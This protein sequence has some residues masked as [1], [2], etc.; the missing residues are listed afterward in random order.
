VTFFPLALL[1]S[2]AVRARGVFEA[3]TATADKLNALVETREQEI[4]AGLRDLQR[5]EREALLLEERARIMRDMHD[6]IGGQ[7]LGLVMRARANRLSGPAL[8]HGLEESLDDL[9]LMVGS[10]EQSDGSLATA[11]G[12]YRARIEPRC[13]AAGAELVWRIENVGETPGFG[14]DR[15][16]QVYRILQ[17]ACNNALKHGHPDRIE[18]TLRRRHEG[19]V[20]LSLEDNGA[21]FDPD[22]RDRRA[23]PGQHATSGCANWRGPGH[24][25]GSGRVANRTAH[26]GRGRT[27][28]T[29]DSRLFIPWTSGGAPGWRRRVSAQ[30]DRVSPVGSPAQSAG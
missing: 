26:E 22:L 12:A 23:G 3:A 24:P 4:L 15:T 9:R 1:V 30:E 20:T 11:L 10:L 17:E 28:L 5:S 29:A 18:V 6:G 8:V 2:L 21:G 19:G 7:L 25:V 13:E 27:S 16:L 14:P